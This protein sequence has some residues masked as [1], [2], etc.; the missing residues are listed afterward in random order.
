MNT[1]PY[2][3]SSPKFH[4]TVSHK[5]QNQLLTL[6]IWMSFLLLQG[7]Q[8]RNNVSQVFSHTSTRH[9]NGFGDPASQFW[10]GNENIHQ[11]TVNF[12]VLLRVEL[13]AS[14]GSHCN[15]EFA[16]FA[17]HAKHMGYTV[18]MGDILDTS[19]AGTFPIDIVC[20]L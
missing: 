12:E 13:I 19:T 8:R 4:Q 17:I 10:L 6:D 3:F 15:A 14:D 1:L 2:L 18:Q 16:P 11:L 20:C 7:L 9:K 5:G